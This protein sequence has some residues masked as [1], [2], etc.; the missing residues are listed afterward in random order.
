MIA[1]LRIL[2]IE[3]RRS[4]GGGRE[5][6]ERRRPSQTPAS[7]A[8][9]SIRGSRSVCAYAGLTVYD[10]DAKDQRVPYGSY[11]R[12]LR[13]LL[14]AT[15]SRVR[16][17]PAAGVTIAGLT[18]R[19]NAPTSVYGELGS[20]RG[21]T[22]CGDDATANNPEPRHNKLVRSNIRGHARNTGDRQLR[23]ILEPH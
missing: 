23:W 15:L 16:A 12:E 22:V 2:S 21:A 6:Y 5:H 3:G 4:R 10:A 7:H 19:F 18:D 17:M 11:V 20:S 9:I 14:R 8:K 1:I 13:A